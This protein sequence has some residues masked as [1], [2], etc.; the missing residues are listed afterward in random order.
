MGFVGS[1]VKTIVCRCCALVSRE[2]SLRPLL[3]DAES[4][5]ISEEL[6]TTT[7]PHDPVVT[8]RLISMLRWNFGCD[9]VDLLLGVG[10]VSWSGKSRVVLWTTCGSPQLSAR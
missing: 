4:F 9:T 1:P 6:D 7:D 3:A 5:S 8:F 2:T 10:E